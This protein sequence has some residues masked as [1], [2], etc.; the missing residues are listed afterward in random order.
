MPLYTSLLVTP[1]RLLLL[2]EGPHSNLLVLGSEE[3]VEQSPLILNTLLQRQLLALIHNFLARQH[4][5]TAVTRDLRRRCN[6]FLQQLILA[7]LNDLRR[8]TPVP[9]ILATEVIPRQDNLHRPALSNGASETLRRTGT[10]DNTKLD[11]RLSEGSGGGA[12]Q[13]VAHEGKLAAST[14]GVAGDGGDDGFADCVGK[15]RPG[16]DEVLGVGRG[17]GKGFHFFDVGARCGVLC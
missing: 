5:N 1:L 9:S 11:F 13:H 4:S 3:T 6:R 7:P 2:R 12:M 16:G 10:G 14:E 8:K 15:V 17:K